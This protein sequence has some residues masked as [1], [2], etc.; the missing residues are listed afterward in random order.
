MKWLRTWGLALLILFLG[1]LIG[2]RQVQAATNSNFTV[3][4]QYSE[5]Q[6]AQNGYIN[7]LA[8]PGQ[9]QT[10]TVAVKN[11]TQKERT[12]AA[13]LYTGYTSANGQIA[14]DKA[15]IPK[16][17]TLTYSLRQQ[18]E[19]PRKQIV[20]V[21]ANG[22]T[23]VT[24]IVN[25]PNKSFPGLIAGGVR[26]WPLHEKAEVTTTQ[27][28]TLMRNKYAFG[29]PVLIRVRDVVGNAKLKLNNIYPGIKNG[30]TTVFVNT[31]NTAPWLLPAA[32]MTAKISK[33]GS[34]QVLHKTVTSSMS[35]AANSNYNLAIDWDKQRLE[36]GTYHLSYTAKATGGTLGWHFARDFTISAAAAAKYNKQAG[37]KPNYLWL[38]IVIGA[39]ILILLVL[40]G[41]LLG[42][43]GRQADD[44]NEKA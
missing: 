17:S 39:L 34:S 41:Y 9:Q 42:R 1:G 18:T 12:F 31:Q 29:M 24:F 44:R 3:L 22:S 38:Y 25:V 15:A 23:N 20:K 14:Y 30:R 13:A 28:Q 8:T 19:K 16:D 43:R 26:V 27:K 7:V 36:A 37:Y 21:A 11:L 10:I 35:M 5:N 40:S 2:G 33:K 4:P 6:R 32:T